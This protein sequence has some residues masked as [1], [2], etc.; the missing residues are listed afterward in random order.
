MHNIV[1]FW[2][3]ITW[4]A[5]DKDLWWWVNRLRLFIDNNGFDY[6]V[7]NQWISG[8]C[9]EWISK[10][11]LSECTFRNPSILIF[12]VA[13][14]DAWYYKSKDSNNVPIDKFSENLDLLLKI[15]LKYT[16]KII[17]VWPTSVNES[18]VTPIPW[19]KDIY[20]YNK[21]I[22]EYDL[23]M[24]NFCERNNIGYVDT[25][26]LLDYSDLEDWLHPNSKWHEKIFLKVK[27]YVFS[28]FI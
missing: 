7:Y 22:K 21:S 27:E 26:D 4:W 23:I 13:T 6:C 15:S 3:S 16:K 19:N 25:F 5:W 14:N 10:R 24:K 17:F 12:S 28:N 1:V 9:T 8:D 11:I 2:T 18:F 20:Y